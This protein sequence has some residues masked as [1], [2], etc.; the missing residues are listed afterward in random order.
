MT[1]GAI[2]VLRYRGVP[3]RA[4]WSLPVVAL[5]VGGARFAPGAWIAWLFVVTLHEMGHAFWALRYRMDVQEILLHGLG[6][7]C[8]Y[9]G[10]PTPRQ[11]SVVAWGGVMAQAI[12]F[13]VALPVSRLVPAPSAFVED[14]YA[15][16]I[17]ANLYVAL[18]NLVPIPPL[19]GAEA[20][21]LVPMLFRRQP[22]VARKEIVRARANAVPRTLGDAIG[23]VDAG[24]VR[25]TVRRALEEARRD[26]KGPSDDPSRRR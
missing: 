8:A 11:R 14:L 17:G 6:G 22:M 3:I 19:D 10:T 12:L 20:W 21:K 24:A 9:A 16:L 5:L 1:P 2:T 23:P 13:A 15:V 26:S 4:H 18:L 25:D 7:H